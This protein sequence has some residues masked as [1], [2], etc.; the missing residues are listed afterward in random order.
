MA[1]VALVA[2]AVVVRWCPCRWSVRHRVDPPALAGSG[3]AALS[4][5]L[6]SEVK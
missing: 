1:V 3:R 6:Q 2:V 5:S 4:R